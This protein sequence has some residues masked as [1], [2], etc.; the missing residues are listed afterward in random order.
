MAKLNL[1]VF[2]RGK[3]ILWVIG[4]VVVFVVFY[5]MFNRGGG[6]SASGGTTV[7]QN[8]PSEAMQIA[9]MQTAAALQSAQIGANV[10]TARIQSVNAQAALAGQVA[11]AQLASGERVA[12]E[13]LAAD[14]E[15]SRYNA[16]ANIA[17]NAQ[18]LAYGIESARLASETAIGLKS[19]DAD[20]VKSQLVT[21]AAMFSKQLDTNAMMFAEQSRNLVAQTALSQIGTLKKKNRDEALTA[22]TSSL[23]GTPN[24]YVPQGGGGFGIGDILGVLSPAYAALH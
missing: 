1:A 14:R 9:G 5:M 6:A 15:A 10:E 22:L 12:L 2:K 3:P 24:T 13:T 7:V 8:G 19:I 16:D 21:N 11:L 4:A 23:T 17:I 20:I 18:N